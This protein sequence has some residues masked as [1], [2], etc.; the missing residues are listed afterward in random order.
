MEIFDHLNGPLK[1]RVEKPV[2]G[3]VETRANTW[4][5]VST[6]GASTRVQSCPTRRQYIITP[7]SYSNLPCSNLDALVNL[8]SCGK[9]CLCAWKRSPTR[10]HAGP[11]T[12]TRPNRFQLDFCA[13]KPGILRA[14]NMICKISYQ[15]HMWTALVLLH[16]VQ[17][18]T[19]FGVWQHLRTGPFVWHPG[20]CV[21]Y[22]FFFVFTP[23]FDPNLGKFRVT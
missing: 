10:G 6:R 13:E 4:Q 15:Y 19:P 21:T 7:E 20:T 9:W 17:F 18:V 22:E 14:H 1:Y 3:A 16:F 8:W 12:P 11:R 2:G 23:F 5:R